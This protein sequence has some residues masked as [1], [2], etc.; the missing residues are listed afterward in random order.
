MER[1][2]TLAGG[3]AVDD[4]PLQ[5]PARFN[6][7]RDVVEALAEADPRRQALT[8]VN[9]EGIIDRH[10]FGEIA[11][12]ANRWAALLRARGLVPGDRLLVFVGETPAWHTILLGALK[13]GLVPVPCPEK[14][15]AR[16][17]AFRG[18]HSEAQLVVTDR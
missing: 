12:D 7:T 6:F 14:L 3:Q 10:T 1:I 9:A 13:A 16:E 5:A 15:R 8:F 17:L 4:D 18:E 11:A 2:L